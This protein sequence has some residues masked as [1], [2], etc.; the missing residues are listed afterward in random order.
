LRD[1]KENTNKDRALADK[2][3]DK[4]VEDKKALA[5]GQDATELEEKIMAADLVRQ[6]KA[7]LD[8]A[9]N[10]EYDEALKTFI[11]N[12]VDY[13]LRRVSQQKP[14]TPQRRPSLGAHR[15]SSSGAKV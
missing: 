4:L 6:E 2:S 11:T 9:S 1:A 12:I 14:R 13:A 7:A 10:K 15:S 5:P 8:K 3:Y